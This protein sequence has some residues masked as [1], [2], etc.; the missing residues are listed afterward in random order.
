VF[1]AFSGLAICISV[2]PGFRTFSLEVPGCKGIPLVG[3]A[4]GRFF[5]SMDVNKRLMIKAIVTSNKFR[6]FIILFKKADS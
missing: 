3:C 2:V 6:S 1:N 5:W 4:G